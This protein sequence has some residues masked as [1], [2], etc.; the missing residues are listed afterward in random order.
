MTKEEKLAELRAQLDSVSRA[1]DNEDRNIGRLNSLSGD[2]GSIRREIKMI[3]EPELFVFP[4]YDR[5]NFWQSIKDN[6]Y[7]YVKKHECGSKAR[8][9]YP[10]NLQ[11]S[12][13]KKKQPW[14]FEWELLSTWS[15]RR[16]HY[17]TYRLTKIY[18][19]SYVDAK[20][21]ENT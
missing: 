3:E 1:M 12:A 21:A 13:V 2:M 10:E 7:K 8:W 19:P 9:A 6:D 17:E 20:I 11:S 15:S 18:E 5:D 14:R 16:N 4:T